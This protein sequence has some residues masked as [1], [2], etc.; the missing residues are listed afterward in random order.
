MEV[1][2]QE[3]IFRTAEASLDL[4]LAQAMPLLVEHSICCEDNSV[5]SGSYKENYLSWS[6]RFFR[7]WPQDIFTC[8][9]QVH[10]SC[11]QPVQASDE[12][13]V[14]VRL[15]A[16]KFR[17]GQR[18]SIDHAVEHEFTLDQVA[19]QGLASVVLGNFQQG[20]SLLGVAL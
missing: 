2:P 11:W 15:R 4:L 16:E 6:I 5:R 14:K 19:A 12:P 9:V 1:S 10:V 18:S 17:T 7:T 20:A 13:C 8:Q 3:Q